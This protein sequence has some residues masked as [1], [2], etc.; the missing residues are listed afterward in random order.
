MWPGMGIDTF[1]AELQMLI[2]WKI[3]E[4]FFLDYLPGVAFF[5]TLI[6]LAL[7]SFS[8]QY[9]QQFKILCEEK[10]FKFPNIFVMQCESLSGR[11][12]WVSRM[13]MLF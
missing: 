11:C 7:G 9:L 3:F 12:F 1:S 13:Y 4:V 10:F 6:V 5:A 2:V 8:L